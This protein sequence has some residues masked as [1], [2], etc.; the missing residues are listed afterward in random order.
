MDWKVFGTVFAGAMAA[1]VVDK[2]IEMAV[3]HFKDNTSAKKKA[4]VK[5]ETE[6]DKELNTISSEIPQDPKAETPAPAPEAPKAETPVQ[7]APAQAAAEATAAVDT[8]AQA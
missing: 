8:Q 1:I 5:A 6:M 7:E 2:G 3:D 4:G